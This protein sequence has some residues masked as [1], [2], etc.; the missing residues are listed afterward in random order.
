MIS[1]KRK[2][3]EVLITAD[4]E[5]GAIE[6]IILIQEENTLSMKN[7]RMPVMP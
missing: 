3:E 2:E 5:E 7:A 6:E 1:S 4:I